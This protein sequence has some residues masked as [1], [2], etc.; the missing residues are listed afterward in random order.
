MRGTII[1]TNSPKC[2]VPAA[3]LIALLGGLVQA[4]EK[5]AR[6]DAHGDA[7]PEGAVARLG[8]AR[9]RH[10]GQVSLVA[11]LPDGKTFLSAG[12]DFTVRI[13]DIATGKE[14]RRM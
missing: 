9:L 5:K 10:G 14:V 2:W 13:W 3:L 1:M 12:A 8:S 6:T 7:L 11:P 4:D